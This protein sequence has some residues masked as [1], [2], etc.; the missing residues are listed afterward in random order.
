MAQSENESNLS[1][2]K[3]LE[4]QKDR[5]DKQFYLSNVIIISQLGINWYS[6]HLNSSE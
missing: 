5:R 6:G 4:N 3:A 2:E 1:G